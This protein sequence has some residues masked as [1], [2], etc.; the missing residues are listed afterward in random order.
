[1]RRLEKLVETV[2]EA[3]KEGLLA[4]AEVER[5]RSLALELRK[6]LESSVARPPHPAGDRL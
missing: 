3:Q 5:A 4:Q 6:L 1:V 2:R